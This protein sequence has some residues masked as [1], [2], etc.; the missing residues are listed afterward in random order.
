MNVID[1]SYRRAIDAVAQ[2]LSSAAGAMESIG[3][4][5][6]TT[7]SAR[8]AKEAIQAAERKLRDCYLHYKV[9]MLRYGCVI[10]SMFS[11][12]RLKRKSRY[13]LLRNK[14]AN[15]LMQ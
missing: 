13:L 2:A 4:F 10:C 8:T 14:T 12:E 7:T 6:D 5:D 1:L 15:N 9:T 3:A 11:S